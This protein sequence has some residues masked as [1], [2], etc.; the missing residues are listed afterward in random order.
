MFYTPMTGIS[1]RQLEALDFIR[2]FIR[3]K[4]Y[5]PSIREIA[6]GLN[7]AISNTHRVVEMLEERGHIRRLPNKSR[8]IE[9][10]K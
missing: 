4:R 7:T 2:R 3:R 1:K 6:E 10:V 9:V 8:T 5:S